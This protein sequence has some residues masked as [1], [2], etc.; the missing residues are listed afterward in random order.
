MK[1][2]LDVLFVRDK[3]VCPWW[4]CFTFDNPIRRLFHDPV[5][6]LS[7]YVGPGN[8]AIDIGPGM[9]FF[10]VAMCGLVGADGRVIAVDIQERMLESLSRR[11]RRRNL[12][13]RLETHLATPVGLGIASR[14]DF[15]LRR[16]ATQSGLYPGVMI[17]HHDLRRTFGHLA[18]EA[19]LDLVQLQHLQGHQSVDMTA[20]YIGLDAERMREGLQ[21]F[22]AFMVEKGVFQELG[23]N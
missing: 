13:D 5:G 8:T 20:H 1:S 11:V 2:L 14:A 6:I 12:A 7:P 4:C 3:H 18:H 23:G 16:V 10:T 15:I 19:G 9:G 21:R 17:S 22:A